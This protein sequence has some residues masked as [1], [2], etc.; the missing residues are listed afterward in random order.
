MRFNILVAVAAIVSFLVL[1]P[2]SLLASESTNY[3]VVFCKIDDTGNSYQA[4]ISVEIPID[5]LKKDDTVLLVNLPSD[6]SISQLACDVP[7]SVD[8]A[9]NQV[10]SVAVE[11]VSKE[12]YRIHVK[13]SG[14]TGGKG[15]FYLE[16]ENIRVA[17]NYTG[18]VDVDFESDES[19]VFPGESV[20][21]TT[22][23]DGK[24]D[25]KID[26]IAY[27]GEQGGQ[28]D[29]LRIKESEAGAFRQGSESL[30]M[31]I[32]EGFTW[33][34]TSMDLHEIWGDLE[35]G[36]V[37]VT[38]NG[39][40]LVFHVLQ[41]SRKP[42]YLQV[43]G[44]R[45]EPDESLLKL[46]ACDINASLE[47]S[48]TLE[49][50]TIALAKYSRI[51]QSVSAS[52]AQLPIVVSGREDVKIGTFTI[53]ESIPESFLSGR[54][55]VLT[56]PEK[57]HW[58]QYPVLDSISRTNGLELSPWQWA[59][60]DERSIK[61]VVKESS[62]SEPASLLWK[63]GEVRL[64]TGISPGDLKLS[65][66]GSAISVRQEVAVARIQPPVTAQ[67]GTVPSVQI[68]ASDQV[69]ADIQLVESTLESVMKEDGKDEIRLYLPSGVEF[70]AIPAV[71]VTEGNLPI[72][73]SSVMTGYDQEMGC[74]FLSFRV[75]G[76]SLQ[77]SKIQISNIRLRISRS[78]PEG[79]IKVRVKGSALDETADFDS[80][81]VAEVAIAKAV[82]ANQA[83][84]NSG[85]PQSAPVQAVFTVG[86]N[87]FSCN[88]TDVS[89]DSAPYIEDERLFIP[90]R[91]MARALGLRDQDLVW[92]AATGQITFFSAQGM[93]QFKVGSVEWYRNGIRAGVM[94][95]APR[96]VPPGR[97]T[98]PVRAIAEI[99]GATVDW[100]AV[101]SQATVRRVG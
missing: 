101:A 8:N 85:S 88:G 71:A 4:K 64:D 99:F 97:V 41:Q 43:K 63:D 78:V 48:S 93:I 75:K 47:G 29:T 5:M 59:D 81:T 66:G 84:G 53:A 76:E 26:S 60:D 17:S 33:I 98:L 49:E 39:R 54:A 11:K 100:N 73:T 34:T 51:A 79:E 67:V 70:M 36:D 16:I 96:I 58:T 56:L 19:D 68:G 13:P 92:D 1:S 50:E 95:A 42:A 15:L 45:I 23:S 82:L 46:N 32:P 94:D 31:K 27:F 12:E 57:A 20:T 72:D 9:P 40:T 65:I 83:A 38:D 91:D 25:L 10:D 30:K 21:L 69:A 14:N 2:T 86:A 87:H 28:L 22:I 61:A 55:I 90:V 80:D 74:S 77:P 52:S 18:D 7:K 6:I 35:L 44:L 89:M 3:N 24:V 62:S 37:T